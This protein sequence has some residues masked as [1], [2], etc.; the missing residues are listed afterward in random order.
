[1][2]FSTKLQTRQKEICIH[3]ICYCMFY[4]C[5]Y[6]IVFFICTVLFNL[7]LTIIFRAKHQTK[8]HLYTILCFCHLWKL[9]RVYL[10]ILNTN[11]WLYLSFTNV[12]GLVWAVFLIKNTSLKKF[13]LSTNSICI[14]PISSSWIKM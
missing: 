1:M 3:F 13:C 5:A 9:I 12:K 6:G 8:S 7:P 2:N 11:W 14:V 10:I 4:T